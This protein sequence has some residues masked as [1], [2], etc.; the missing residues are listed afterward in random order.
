MLNKKEIFLILA[1]AVVLAFAASLIRTFQ[2]FLYAL[3]AVFA[4]IMINVTA[5]KIL[6]FYLD[7]EIEIKLWEIVRYGFKPKNYFKK[8]I[9]AGVL[10]PIIFAALSFGRLIWMA[11]L[12]FEVKPKIYRAAKRHGLYTFSEMTEHHLALIAAA[13]IFANLAFAVA[14]YLIGF[15]EFA[16]LN[17]FYAFFNLLPLSDLDGNKIFFGNIMLWSFLTSIALIGLGYVFFII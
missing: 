11:S 16:R 4:V 3:L 10:F 7:S 12:V 6:S 5:K 2:I 9:P 17:V 14:G 8:P 1:V 13:G 15:S